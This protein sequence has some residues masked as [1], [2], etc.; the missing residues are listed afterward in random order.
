VLVLASSWIDARCPTRLNLLCSLLVCHILYMEFISIYFINNSSSFPLICKCVTRWFKYNRDWLCVNKS[1]FVPVIFEPPFT[2]SHWELSEHH[3]MCTALQLQQSAK[4]MRM[5]LTSIYAVGRGSSVGIATVYGLD[6]PGI[7]SQWRRDTTHPS[8]PALHLHSLLYNG[9]RLSC[10]ELKRPGR[11]FNHP[12]NS[13]AEVK[14][15]VE[16]YLYSP[17]GA[18]WLVLGR[19]LNLR[20]CVPWCSRTAMTFFVALL[21]SLIS[22]YS[23]HF[24]VKVTLTCSLELCMIIRTL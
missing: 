17:S 10:P 12:L 13:N 19:N 1:Q 14:E 9:Y 20:V 3:G 22:L 15:R 4:N 2:L 6:C 23:Q 5:L 18:S 8:I 21:L 16:L 7:E 24:I 11:G